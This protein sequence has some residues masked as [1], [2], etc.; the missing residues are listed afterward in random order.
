MEAWNLCTKAV[1]DGSLVDRA[2]VQQ[3]NHLPSQ[4]AQEQPEEYT[5][6]RLLDVVAVKQTI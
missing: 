2:I 3:D 6:F 5:H 1:D 4:V